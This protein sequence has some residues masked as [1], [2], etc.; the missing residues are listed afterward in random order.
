MAAIR[1]NFTDQ[2]I[3]WKD[4]CTLE[5]FE[6]TD[7]EDEDGNL[8]VPLCQKGFNPLNFIYEKDSGEYNLTRFEKNSELLARI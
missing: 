3:G 7:K 8:K 1:G 5:K 4:L 6:E 2:L